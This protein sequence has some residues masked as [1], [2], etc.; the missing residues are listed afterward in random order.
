MSKSRLVVSIVAVVVLAA[1]ALGIAILR[2]PGAGTAP[3]AGA[4]AAPKPGPPQPASGAGIAHAYL[5]GGCFWC[6][7]TA[8]EGV[9]GVVSVVSGYTGGPEPNPSYDQVSAGETGHYESIDVAFLAKQ[10]SYEKILD[11]FWHNID[12]TQGDGQ[13]CDRGAQYRSAIFVRDEAQRAAAEKSKRAIEES[14][15]LKAPIVT[16]ILPAGEFWAA[17][18]YH[19]DFWKK[20]PVRY[21]TY[22]FGCG[23]DRR[24]DEIWGKD[25]RRGSPKH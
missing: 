8:F 15:R 22:R 6:L 9:P 14:K 4:A 12:P 13:F 5:A 23:R 16:A 18:E 3:D 20:D 24:L 11:I 1:S 10:V 2:L 25:A 19:Q 7:E 17:E 21:Q